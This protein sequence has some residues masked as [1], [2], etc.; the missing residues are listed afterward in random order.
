MELPHI[1]LVCVIC[2]RNDYLP[3][4]CSHCDKTVCIDHKSNHGSDCPLNKT[5]F[6]YDLHG[7]EQNSG[8]KQSCDYCRKI[9]LKLE[10]VEC[11]YCKKLHCLYHRHQVQH[12]CRQLEDSKETY[13]KIVEERSERQ[14]NALERLKESCKSTTAS[15]LTHKPCPPLD[16]KKQELAKRI[17]IM[18]IKQFARG[19]PNILTEDRYYFQIKFNHQPNSPISDITKDGKVIKIYTTLKHTIGRM[20][21]WSAD[22]LNIKN[23][24]HI[25]EANQLVF[26]KQFND[27]ESLVLDSQ[28]TFAFYL[29][30]GKLENGDEINLTYNVE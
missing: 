4:K 27:N 20:I 3:F 13:K 24:N 5:N 26:T 29:D 1:G 12:D 19:P 23:K 25:Q 2:R 9:T 30:E 18:K 28:K 16:P 14:K 7:V 8:L 17:R 11:A 6:E 22:E 15:S 21:D 10:L